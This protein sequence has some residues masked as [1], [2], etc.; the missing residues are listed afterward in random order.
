MPKYGYCPHSDPQLKQKLLTASTSPLKLTTKNYNYMVSSKTLQYVNQRVTPKQITIYKH[1]LLL[2]KIYNDQSMS[3]DW[4]K[5]L[6]TTFQ[7][8]RS[9]SKVFHHLFAQSGQQHTHKQTSPTQC[10]NYNC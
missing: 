10:Q 9:H 2:H 8:K 1:V 6:F 5:F 3:N 7:S 4:V